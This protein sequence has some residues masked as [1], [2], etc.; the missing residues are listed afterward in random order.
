MAEHSH[1]VAGTFYWVIPAPALTAPDDW[2]D[3]LQPARFL[4][5]DAAGKLLLRCGLDG[6]SDWPM[7]WIGK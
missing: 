4:G 5:R 3:G 2:Q 6:A 7:R 1:L